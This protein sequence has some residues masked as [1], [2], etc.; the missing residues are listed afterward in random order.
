MCER[1]RGALVVVARLQ[2]VLSHKFSE[3]SLSKVGRTSHG[4]PLLRLLKFQS[5]LG[6]A[7]VPIVIST[8]VHQHA[9]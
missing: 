1:E 3:T 5:A 7:H 8:Q 4:E 9:E 6:G 2:L